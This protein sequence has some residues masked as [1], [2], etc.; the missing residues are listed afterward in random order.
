MNTLEAIR[1]RKSVRHFTANPV[2]AE[3]IENVL[4]AGVEAPS[5]KNSQPWKYYVV[6]GKAK[7]KL[8]ELMNEGLHFFG[9]E[10]TLPHLPFYASVVGSIQTMQ[11]A[12]VVILVFNTG[13]HTM[14]SDGSLEA[15][16]M[17]CAAMQ[18]MGATIQNMLLAATDQGLGSLWMCDVYYAYEQICSWLGEQSQLAAAIALGHE[19]GNSPKPPRHNLRDHTIYFEDN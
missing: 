3:M 4:L 15:R 17:D 13:I 8:A 19:D 14:N 5:T 10:Q 9:N 16:F 2:T 11:S 12:P 1:T 18:T 7:D 6:Q